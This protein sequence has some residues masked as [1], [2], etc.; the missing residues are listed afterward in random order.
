MSTGSYMI[1]VADAGT[2]SVENLLSC[3]EMLDVETFY[4]WRNVTCGEILD[5]E[6]FFL[7]S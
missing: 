4:M 5:V 1:F 2:L 6:I 3:G 7:I